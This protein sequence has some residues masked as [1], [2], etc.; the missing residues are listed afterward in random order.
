VA[1]H[2]SVIIIGVVSWV[3]FHVYTA[4]GVQNPYD[5]YLSAFAFGFIV[6]IVD[7]LLQS[8]IPSYTAHVVN[9]SISTVKQ[10]GYSI[11]VSLY[12]IA[13]YVIFFTLPI[14]ANRR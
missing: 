1:R 4:S 8:T 11:Y 10:L 6:D 5:L 3:L 7:W 13:L 9:N 2:I 14:S 12:L